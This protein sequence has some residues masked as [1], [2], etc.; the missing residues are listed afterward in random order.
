MWEIFLGGHMLSTG[1]DVLNIYIWR[2][3]FCLYSWDPLN[4]DASDR[5][6]GLFG[7]ISRRRGASAWFQGV[8]TWVVEEVLQYW[9]ISSLKI[10]LNCSWTFRRNWNVPLVLLER[11]WWAGLS[12]IYLV[13]FFG[14][15]MWEILIFK[16]F[17]PLKIHM[18]SQKTRFWKEKSVENGG[19]T[20]KL[21]IIQFKHD[22]LS[23]LAVQKVDTYIAKQC[24]HVEFP[25]FVMGSHL[26]QGTGHAI[27]VVI[28]RNIIW[29]D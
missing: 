22:F 6:L 15:R 7:K 24:S 20:W 3:A 19:N 12:G 1:G 28:Q 23:Y 17:L 8:W 27:E 14:F 16:W 25:Y 10:K 4:W 11:S 5:A 29:I 18:N 26:G 21:I 2:K 9:M 13:R